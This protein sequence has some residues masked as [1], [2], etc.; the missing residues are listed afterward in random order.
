MPADFLRDDVCALAML[1]AVLCYAGG[2]VVQ[3]HDQLR[4]RGSF[5]GLF[6]VVGLVGWRVFELQSLEPKRLLPVVVFGLLAGCAV[7]GAAWIALPTVT[8]LWSLTG[9]PLERA[10]SDSRRQA[11]FRREER[12]RQKAQRQAEKQRLV[13]ERTLAPQRERERREAEARA[14]L[15]AQ[16][17]QVRAAQQA[18]EQLVRDEL[19]TRVELYYSLH[20][21]ELGPRF[22]PEMFQQFVT[23]HLGDERPIEVVRLRAAQLEQLLKEHLEKIVPPQKHQSLEE[24]TVWLDEQN[25]RIDGVPDE[26]LREFLR[27]MLLD[28]YTT[29]TA[30]TFQEPVR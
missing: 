25:R 8:Y 18:A 10:W 9:A 30:A 21:P 4:Q 22:T 29:R 7:A 17:S 27:A 5:L 16:Q 15:A 19:R 26:S 13:Q 14:L 24:L 12:R 2:F 23:K 1:A 3:G 20:R 28:Q 6:T 11:Q